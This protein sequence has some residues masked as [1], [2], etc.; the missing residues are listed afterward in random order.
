MKQ[1]WL[2]PSLA[3]W[4]GAGSSRDAEVQD[5]TQS[6]LRHDFTA[7]V[8]ALPHGIPGQSWEWEEVSF[9]EG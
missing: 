5:G 1:L 4:R 9:A 2:S 8:V 7:R 3:D 6:F